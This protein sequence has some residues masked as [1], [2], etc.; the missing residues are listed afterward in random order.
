MANR[1]TRWPAHWRWPLPA[2]LAWLLAWLVFKVLADLGAS[3]GL[4]LGAASALG[5]ACS[6]WGD[7]WWR[8][9]LIGAGFPLSLAI[10]LASLASLASSLRDTC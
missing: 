8:R 6:L 10:S 4:A 5:V 7:S 1:S 3:A 2:I 9:L